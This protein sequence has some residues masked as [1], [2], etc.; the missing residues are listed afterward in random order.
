LS[1]WSAPLPDPF[2]VLAFS[3]G[4]M[5]AAAFAHGALR[6]LSHWKRG[7]ATLLDHVAL[8]SSVSGGSFTAAH[9]ALF[10]S[11]GF[12]RFESEFLFRNIQFFHLPRFALRPKNWGKFLLRRWGPLL[13][14]YLHEQLYEGKCFRD[15]PAWP[16]LMVNATDLAMARRF[17]FTQRDFDSIG[18]NLRAQRIGDAVAASA[19]FPVLL[20]PVTLPNRGAN[21][22]PAWVSNGVKD[23]HKNLERYRAANAWLTY[24]NT[25]G[26]PYVH[27]GDGGLSDNTGARAIA[28]SLADADEPP[29]LFDVLSSSTSPRQLAIFGVDAKTRPMFKAARRASPPCALSVLLTATTASM[30]L[31]TDDSIQ[32]VEAVLSNFALASGVHVPSTPIPNY[33]YAPIGWGPNRAYVGH[34]S[35]DSEEDPDER[36]ELFKVD[37]TL[38]LSGR[39]ICRLINS[40]RRLLAA[41]PAFKRLAHDANFTQR[42]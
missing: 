22:R 3:G 31:R 25:K 19:A 5:R 29:A 27:L 14:D 35:F 28:E 13:A 39:T 40:G 12:E 23:L 36:E 6:E 9:F 42:P 30:D 15:L 34:V 18:G 4:G 24:E 16:K 26:Y 11:K 8:V 10:G 21:S 2:I 17:S 33:P 38:A 41:N 20:T 32:Q 1:A 37:T 7:D